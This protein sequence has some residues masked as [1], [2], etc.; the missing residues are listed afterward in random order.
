M[1]GSKTKGLRQQDSLLVNAGVFQTYIHKL[2]WWNT[3]C[4]F[5]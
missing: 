4:Q 2:W 5:N 1:D 3:C